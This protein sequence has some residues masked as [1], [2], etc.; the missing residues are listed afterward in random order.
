M[1][2]LDDIEKTKPGGAGRRRPGN[3]YSTSL[4]RGIYDA[5]SRNASRPTCGNMLQFAISARSIKTPI[6]PDWRCAMIILNYPPVEDAAAWLIKSKPCLATL[7]ECQKLFGLSASQFPELC[8]AANKILQ[9]SLDRHDVK[10][11]QAIDAVTRIRVG[12]GIAS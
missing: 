5:P 8:A 6:G 1:R 3:G 12:G 7:N 2:G 4:Q 9:N 11:Q 10:P